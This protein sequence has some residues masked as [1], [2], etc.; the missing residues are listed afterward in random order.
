MF[1]CPL[2]LVFKYSCYV[3]FFIY[4]KV[5]HVLF[6]ENQVAGQKNNKDAQSDFRTLFPGTRSYFSRC[7]TFTLPASFSCCSKFDH[8]FK[9]KQ[10]INVTYDHL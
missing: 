6:N 8:V 5:R 7:K 4:N 3:R 9:E 2:S 10:Y 1:F